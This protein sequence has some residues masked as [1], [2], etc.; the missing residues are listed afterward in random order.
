M[1]CRDDIEVLI[2]SRRVVRSNSQAE[3]QGLLSQIEKGVPVTIHR[4]A[5]AVIFVRFRQNFNNIQL[6]LHR[7]VE[8]AEWIYRV[9]VITF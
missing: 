7:K 6:D 9:L 5:Q 1:R 3:E 8:K 2:C 4:Y